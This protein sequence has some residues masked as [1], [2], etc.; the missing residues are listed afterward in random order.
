LEQRTAEFRHST[1]IVRYSI[2]IRLWRI[3]FFSVSFSI[4]LAASAASGEAEPGTLE[5]LNL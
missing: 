2:F 3:R 1:F 4:K 5:R